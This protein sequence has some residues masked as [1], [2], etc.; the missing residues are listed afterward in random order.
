MLW[1]KYYYVCPAIVTTRKDAEKS[2][3]VLNV[4]RRVHSLI[5]LTRKEYW[6][7]S[8]IATPGARTGEITM[9]SLS[10]TVRSFHRLFAKFVFL[11][12]GA[13]LSL[14]AGVKGQRFCFRSICFDLLNIPYDWRDTV[15][16]CKSSF[17]KSVN[18]QQSQNLCTRILFFSVSIGV[19]QSQGYFFLP[20][21]WEENSCYSIADKSDSDPQETYGVCLL[22]VITESD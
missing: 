5:Y 22:S 10:N 16:H 6:P 18:I 4:D 19:S 15:S 1:R 9:F 11:P 21:I 7:R 12:P 8:L 20:T 3:C 13:N 17:I 14:L 2:F